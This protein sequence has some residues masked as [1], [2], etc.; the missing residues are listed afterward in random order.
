MTSLACLWIRPRVE[1]H[2]DGALGPRMARWV[3]AHL[4]ACRNCLADAD[5]IRRLRTLV[6]AAAAEPLEPDWSGFWAGVQTRIARERSL[7]V[8]DAWWFPLW[9]A[10]W[11]HPRLS[12]GSAMAA[13]LLIA[14]SLWQP[15]DQGE[16]PLW[17]TPVI[18]QDVSAP[19]PDTSVMVYSMPDQAVTVIWL[20]GPDGPNDES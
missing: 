5:A 9:R 1:R 15:R 2:V 14:L 12:L 18:V 19:D 3:E 10:F 6:K 11:G 4:A 8:K 20:F 17:S 7:P 16:S 13:G